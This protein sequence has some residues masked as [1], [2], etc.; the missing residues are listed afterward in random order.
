MTI[1]LLKISIILTSILFIGCSGGGDTSNTQQ[2]DMG[3][4]I[5][6]AVEGV[7]YAS[8]NGDSGF[9]DSIGGFKYIKNSTVTFNIGGIK[10]GSIDSLEYDQKVLIGEIV[11]ENRLYDIFDTSETIKLAVF[12][13][14]LDE[15][16][17]P[18]NGI[19]ITELMRNNFKDD[20]LTLIDKSL[21]EIE[22]MII[23]KTNKTPKTTAEAKEHLNSTFKSLYNI[24]LLD[25]NTDNTIQTIVS[26]GDT[27]DIGDIE[28][29]LKN[30]DMKNIDTTQP[31]STN[32]NFSSWTKIIDDKVINSLVLDSQNNICIS[33]D[34]NII[35]YDN[36]SKELLSLNDGGKMAL[37][38]QDN[39][40]IGKYIDYYSY[41]IKK[42]NRNGEYIWSKIFKEKGLY[43][44][45]IITDKD[46]NIYIT[47]RT[48]SINNSYDLFITKFNEDGDKLW[49][50][51]LE[52]EKLNS[53]SKLVIDKD[54]NIYVLGSSYSATAITIIINHDKLSIANNL[55]K[56]VYR[57]VILAK[58]NSNGKK[59]WIKVFGTTAEDYSKSMAIDS[60]NFIYTLHT[61][62]FNDSYINTY[63][64]KYNTYGR[65]EWTKQLD[66]EESDYGN[67]ITVDSKDNIYIAGYTYSS[68][69][70]IPNSGA[71]DIFIAKYDT[72]GNQQYIK[73]ISNPT[74]D[75]ANIIVT[76]KDDNLYIA[77]TIKDNNGTKGLLITLPSD[78]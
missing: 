28:D 62:P 78:N 39:I 24:D 20:N 44:N 66:I 48:S 35:I 51:L 72:N 27:E 22:N 74:Q 34:N 6:S 36:N 76:D 73:S 65:F 16:N 30:I 55:H 14:S 18:I 43:I 40:I 60:K 13:Q 8:S 19:K 10:L 5:D 57:E 53:A 71:G 46:D 67:S 64:S 1:K 45:D 7:E 77:G 41:A 52:N 21:F 59:Q 68:I 63:I 31:N 32:I 70:N 42:Y 47:G 56:E 38:T 9:T 15:D 23:Q 61:S 11:N 3:Y 2:K 33:S 49:T 17:N 26:V 75:K 58:Y 69:N 4:L 25:I 29:I 54:N 37:D 12:L 50:S